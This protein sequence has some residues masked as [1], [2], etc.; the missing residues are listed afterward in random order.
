M[1]EQHGKAG[2]LVVIIGVDA[3]GARP[4]GDFGICDVHIIAPDGGRDESL[5]IS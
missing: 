2:A 5:V 3:G 4:Q 1:D